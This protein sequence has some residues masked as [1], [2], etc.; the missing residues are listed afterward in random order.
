MALKK[1]SH[2][3]V[4][5]HIWRPSVG[6]PLNGRQ[7][8][9]RSSDG[10]V[11]SVR[12]I[13]YWSAWDRPWSALVRSIFFTTYVAHRLAGVPIG[14]LSPGLLLAAARVDEVGEAVDGD[15]S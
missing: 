10:R 6:P 15:A 9:G 13:L 2:L 8:V 11:V 3:P 1:P 7:A 5:G 14:S 4:K 12:G